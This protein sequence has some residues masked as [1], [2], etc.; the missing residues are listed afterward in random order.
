MLTQVFLFCFVLYCFVFV[1][2]VLFPIDFHLVR[3]RGGGR[4]LAARLLSD[5]AEGF[6]RLPLPFPKEPVPE[7]QGKRCQQTPKLKPTD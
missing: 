4:I 2:P 3:V 6:A 1:G 5:A 7:V